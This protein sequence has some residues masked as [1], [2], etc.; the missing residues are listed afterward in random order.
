MSRSVSRL[1][2]SFI[3]AGV[4]LF[5]LKV[6]ETESPSPR[7]TEVVIGLTRVSCPISGTV[8]DVLLGE[9]YVTVRSSDRLLL[10]LDLDL[11]LW[12][13]GVR[14]CL[15]CFLLVSHRRPPRG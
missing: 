12:P 5:A 15:G 10:H 11:V 3:Q 2:A 9:R 13:A 7:S 6:I 4:I 1:S 8:V 14:R